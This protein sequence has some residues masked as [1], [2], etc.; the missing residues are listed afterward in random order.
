MRV[1]ADDVFFLLDRSGAM[2][3][4]GELE[5][6]KRAIVQVLRGLAPAQHFGIFVFD[7]G[8]VQFPSD[9]PPAVAGDAERLASA[10]HF[11]QDISGG[12]GT[13]PQ[14]AFAHAF[15]MAARAPGTVKEMFYVSDGGGA[16]SGSD[17]SAYLRSTLALVGQL[18]MGKVTI[19]T[20]G[21]LDIPRL[22]EK[23]LMDLA[24]QNGGAYTRIPH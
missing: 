12:S 5:H 3:D 20:V 2:Q 23:Y 1:D 7:K 13:C 22:N 17:E 10:A 8:L 21:V 19:N 18:N 9:G 16:C 4:T 24:A 6:F 11:L 15:A 14:P